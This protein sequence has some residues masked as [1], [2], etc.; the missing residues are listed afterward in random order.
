MEYERRMRE[1]LE[2]SRG[3]EMLFSAFV[4]VNI[5]NLMECKIIHIFS[6]NNNISHVC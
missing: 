4:H 6:H 2:K 1:P 3:P 5:S